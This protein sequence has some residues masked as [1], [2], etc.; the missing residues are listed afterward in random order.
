[1]TQNEH[2]SEQRAKKCSDFLVE[3]FSEGIGG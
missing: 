3:G 2:S 1:M